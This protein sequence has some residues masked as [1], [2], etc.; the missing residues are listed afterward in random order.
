MSHRAL[1]T[2]AEAA[3]AHAEHYPAQKD[4]YGPELSRL[5][6]LGGQSSATD[7][8]AVQRA[9]EH[10]SS[11]LI[12]LFAR[13]DVLIAPAIPTAAPSLQ[14]L[15]D[16]RG[17]QDTANFMNFTA[18]WDFS[19]SPTITVP[20]TIGE[21]GVP[22]AFQ[23]IGGLLEEAKIIRAAYVFERARGELAHPLA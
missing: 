23:L 4:L 14:R 18:P 16:L 19:G 8:A 3:M 5:L 2:G 11:A 6:E 17:G 20:A 12:D 1:V 10:F 21:E 22:I 15:G 13:I 7:Y 9:K